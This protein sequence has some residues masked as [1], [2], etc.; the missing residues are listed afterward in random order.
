[1]PQ[2]QTDARIYDAL[3]EILKA[4]VPTGCRIFHANMPLQLMDQ[5]ARESMKICTFLVQQDRIRMNTSGITPVHDVI[6]E[7]SFYGSLADVDDMAKAL[8]TALIGNDIEALGWHFCLYPSQQAG[9][10]DVWDPRI[11][12]K[13]EWLQFRGLA[14][15]PEA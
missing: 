9:K 12:V 1:M 2:S 10:R 13:R 14:I 6:V 7:V 11:Q 15:E 8:N 3:E 5:L 4:V